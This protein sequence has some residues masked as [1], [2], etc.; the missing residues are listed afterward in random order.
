MFVQSVWLWP[1][2]VVVVHI[3]SCFFY[4]HLLYH[5]QGKLKNP[6]NQPGQKT[7]SGLAPLISNLQWMVIGIIAVE[8]QFACPMNPQRP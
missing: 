2:C 5:L 8:E 4:I 6:I 3:V 7:T 1:V